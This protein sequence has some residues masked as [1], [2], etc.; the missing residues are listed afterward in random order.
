MCVVIFLDTM[1]RPSVL[2]CPARLSRV[3]FISN[4]AQLQVNKSTTGRSVRH[5]G[6]K[7]WTILEMACWVILI[8]E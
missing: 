5:G 4:K 3:G 2:E 1:I 7:K 8:A 6:G